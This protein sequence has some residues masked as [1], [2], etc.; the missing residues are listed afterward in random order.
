[1]RPI[2]IAVSLTLS[3]LAIGAGARPSSAQPAEY[4][5]VRHALYED[6]EAL[7]ALGLLR[8]LPIYTRPLARVDIAR[9]LL[10]AQERSG[11][12]DSDMH[13]Q[14]LARE[15]DRELREMGFEPGASESGPL[16][17]VGAREQ[18]FRVALAGH[19]RG[20]FDEKR[21]AAH[22]RLRDE[23]SFSARMG[24][25]LWPGIGAFEELGVTRIR[26]QRGF[27]DAIALH[28]DL[29][30]A[31]LRGELTGR[32]GPLT[33][34]L[35]YESFRW[36]PGR[37][38]TLLL[39]D[40]AGPMTFLS[41]QGHV[42]GRVSATGT[43][44]SAVIS[45]AD[46]RYLAAHRLEIEASPRVTLGIA[47]AVRYRA[48]GIDPLYAVG[49]L[50]YTFVERIRIRESSDDSLRGL[51]RSN[52]MVSADVACRLSRGLTLYGELLLDDY[53][54]ESA[55]MPN[56]IGYQLG[57]RSERR[58]GAHSVRTLGEYTRVRNYT[59]SVH[60][61]QDFIYRDRPLGF[62]L[63]PDV[64]NVYFE[65]VYDLSRDWQ[66]RWTGDFANHGE[67]RL[68]VPWFPAQGAVSTVG[69]SGIVEERREI[70]GD[71]RWLPRDNV[72]LSV[73]V[74]FRR[75]VNEGNVPG[76]GREAWLGR[77]AAELRY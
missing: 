41:L 42:R 60:Y 71:A 75:V 73:G 72:D 68:G 22:F 53:A 63:G 5:P 47:E 76:G 38:G 65:A 37:R 49:L 7:A 57:F 34:A 69:L 12:L 27:I 35:G 33:G 30:T 46:R 1:M 11:G 3:L 13:Y 10:D 26:G 52:L 32:A 6:L 45:R 19:L 25:Q 39:S 61:A 18:R 14:R 62:A 70:W 48:D 2:A 21:Q 54:T 28:S 59:Y 51:E 9:A 31:V 8:S 74:G 23:T 20:D 24:L 55:D 77:V 58:F 66:I 29:E 15:L 64:E 16:L 67:G 17:D 50:P 4:L 56:R 44:L 43:A 40:A 36:G